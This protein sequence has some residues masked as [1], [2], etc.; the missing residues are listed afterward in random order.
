MALR[1]K[2]VG[3]EFDTDLIDTFRKQL[4]KL[5]LSMDGLEF[6]ENSTTEETDKK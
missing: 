4:Q 3:H 2:V 1:V 6:E 5:H